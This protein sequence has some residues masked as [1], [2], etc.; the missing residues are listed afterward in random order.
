MTTSEP[1]SFPPQQENLISPAYGLFDLPAPGFITGTAACLLSSWPGHC[2]AASFPV[3]HARPFECAVS[4]RTTSGRM[5]AR[6]EQRQ[7]EL[8]GHHP[9]RVVAGFFAEEPVTLPVNKPRS[10]ALLDGAH[11]AP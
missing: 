4:C 6:P 2:P 8:R 11:R 1:A 3:H 5:G 10:S 9:S 7:P